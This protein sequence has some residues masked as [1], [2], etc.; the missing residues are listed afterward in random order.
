MLHLLDFPREHFVDKELWEIGLFANK[1]QSREAMR[2]LQKD[3]SIRFEDMPLRDRAGNEHPVEF[4]SNVYQEGRLLVIQ[5]NIRDIR[6]RK[7]LEDERAGHLSTERS[8]RAEAEVANKAKDKFLAILSHELR[9]PL[10]PVVMTIHAME[11]DPDMPA[12]FREDLAMVRRNI[13]LEV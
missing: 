5:C 10:A 8:L 1:E 7:H 12:K 2:V 9:T 11:A 6:E 13:D 3:K 4:V